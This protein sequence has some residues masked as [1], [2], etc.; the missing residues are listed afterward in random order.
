MKNDETPTNLAREEFLRG[1][2]RNYPGVLP[3]G[4]LFKTKLPDRWFRIHSLPGSKRYP[5]TR[6]EW[7]ELLRRQVAIIDHLVA[8]GS[9]LRIVLNYVREDNQLFDNFSFENI[10]TFVDRDR[11]VVFQSFLA[12]ARWDPARFENLLRQIADEKVR[13]FLIAPDAL[14]APYDGGMDVVLKAQQQRDA[15]KEKFR[16]WLSSRLDGL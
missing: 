5:E 15:M 2:T 11:E 12:E 8:R 1:W 4:H 9:S 14:I 16:S 13:A 10:G 7:D 6:E 3:M